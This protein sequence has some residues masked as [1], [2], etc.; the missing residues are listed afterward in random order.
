MD[1][2]L[3]L[4]LLVFAAAAVVV[5]WGPAPGVTAWATQAVLEAGFTVLAWQLAQRRGQG[6][7]RRNFWEAAAV[8]GLILAAGAVLRAVEAV[9]DP[10]AATAVRTVPTILLTVGTGVLLASMLARPWRLKRSDRTRLWL[11]MVVVLIG[12]AVAIWIVS[13]L[14]RSGATRSGQVV[15]AIVGAVTLLVAA[16]ALIRVVLTHSAPVGIL[17]G[18]S[19]SVAVALFGVD[20]VLNA[21]ILVAPDIR[22]LL[23]ARMVPALVLVAGARFEQLRRPPRRCRRGDGGPVPGCRSWR[24]PRPRCS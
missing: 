22:A 10:E 20:R 11:D 12:A 8:A 23:V 1:R 24:S 5:G 13:V 14:G 18:V 4:A 2:I 21:E 16:F 17:A 6:P 19:L 7:Q 3:G 9:G 15:W